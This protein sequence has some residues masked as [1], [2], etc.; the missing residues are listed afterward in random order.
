MED[1]I[2]SGA[3]FLIL[4]IAF[5]GYGMRALLAAYRTGETAAWTAKAVQG[6]FGVIAGGLFAEVAANLFG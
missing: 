5:G 4:S 6:G 2:L 1:R 3:L